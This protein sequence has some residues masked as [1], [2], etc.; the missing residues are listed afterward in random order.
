VQLIK[1]LQWCSVR[2][3]RCSECLNAEFLGKREIPKDQIAWHP[4]FGD[5]PG[6]FFEELRSGHF[7]IQLT[8]LGA[9]DGKGFKSRGYQIATSPHCG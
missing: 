1:S 3:T 2:E 5:G 6:R 4:S 8:T 7:S 9:A